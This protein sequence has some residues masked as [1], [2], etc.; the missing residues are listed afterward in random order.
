MSTIIG[1]YTL[2]FNYQTELNQMMIS[3][4]ELLHEKYYR[5]TDGYKAELSLT[6]RLQVEITLESSMLMIE[7]YTMTHEQD[8]GF[9][10]LHEENFHE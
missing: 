1:N 10:L 2:T 9:L 3:Q 6:G 5:K 4:Y 8:N 7:S